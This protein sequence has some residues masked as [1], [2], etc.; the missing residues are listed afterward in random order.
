MPATP[1]GQYGKTDEGFQEF[2]RIVERLA[3]AAK[4]RDRAPA[5]AGAL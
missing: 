5:I 2:A 1:P 4:E 3:D